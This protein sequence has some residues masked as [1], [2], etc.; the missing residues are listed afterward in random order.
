MILRGG[1]ALP[2][3]ARV[4]EAG[5]PTAVVV[6]A[7]GAGL[8]PEAS[9][10]PQP[11][12]A[13]P[14]CLPGA[15]VPTHPPG[16]RRPAPLQS[17]VARAHAVQLA[18]RPGDVSWAGFLGRAPQPVALRAHVANAD[19]AT[20]VLFSSGTTGELRCGARLCAVLLYPPAQ[21][22]GGRPPPPRAL[23]PLLALPLPARQAHLARRRPAAQASPRP[24]RGRT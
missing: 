16:A 8:E 14:A 5:A 21:C 24:S 7:R 19:E 3:Y 11:N 13:Q 4:V 18:L 15:A 10:P 6:P 17:H 22:C 9:S 2:L 20:N 1:K 12:P 23:S